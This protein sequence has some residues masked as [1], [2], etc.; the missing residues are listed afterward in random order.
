MNS[1]FLAN[2]CAVFTGTEL[3]LAIIILVCLS[4]SVHLFVAGII[5]RRRLRA[6]AARGLA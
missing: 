2:F 5:D 4:A 3:V 1:H 6:L